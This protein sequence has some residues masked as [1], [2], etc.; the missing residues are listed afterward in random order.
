[1]PNPLSILRRIMFKVR[2]KRWVR[3]VQAEIRSQ[4]AG[5]PWD[6][7]FPSNRETSSDDSSP[8][9]E[10][11]ASVLVEVPLNYPALLEYVLANDGSMER[12]VI[13]HRAH[14]IMCARCQAMFV[15]N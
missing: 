15:D 12:E 5:M 13:A 6:A 3:N 14:I 9:L 2:L 1:M 7:F 8:Y 4:D 11:H 10:Y